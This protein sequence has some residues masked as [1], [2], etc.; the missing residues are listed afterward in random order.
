MKQ[1]EALKISGRM[2]VRSHPAGTIHLYESLV[3]MGRLD[4]ARELLSDGKVHVDQKNLIVDSP[5]CGID[6]LVQYLISSYNGSF[7]F[8]LG[9]SWGEIGTGIAPS[10][11]PMAATGS[12]GVLTG[13]YQ[14]LVTFTNGSGETTAGPASATVN[15][16]SQQVSLTAIPTGITGTITG[17]N[18][19]RTKAGGSTFFLLT[20]IADNTTTTYTDNTADSSLPATQPP[21]TS[22]AGSIS[23]AAGDTGLISPTNRATVS[24]ASDSGLNT[25]TLQFFFPDGSLLNTTY[26]EG[27]SFISGTSTIG[28]GQMFNH[29]LFA[30]PYSKTSGTDTTLE[31]DISLTN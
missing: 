13:A 4:L 9:I 20:T 22:T 14:Y 10:A 23:P 27:G 12:S 7:A 2:I 28:T 24:F 26:Y 6:I 29:A 18:V 25:A 8:P 1:N 30:T 5:S 16:S 3:S 11:A 19:Y 15:P 31:I 21:N 17:R